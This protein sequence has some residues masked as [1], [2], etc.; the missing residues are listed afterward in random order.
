MGGPFYGALSAAVGRLFP[1][2]TQAELEASTSYNSFRSSCDI[3]KLNGGVPPKSAEFGLFS[4]L[5]LRYGIDEATKI[6]MAA[7]ADVG[8]FQF[9]DVAIEYLLTKPKMLVDIDDTTIASLRH[10]AVLGEHKIDC[11]EIYLELLLRKTMD[12]S[13]HTDRSLDASVKFEKC[14]EATVGHTYPR[15]SRVQP[16]IL[17]VQHSDSCVT[18]KMRGRP[19]KKVMKPKTE[20]KCDEDLVVFRERSHAYALGRSPDPQGWPVPDAIFFCRRTAS[21]VIPNLTAYPVIMLHRIVCMTLGLT[22][23]MYL[24]NGTPAALLLR[25]WHDQFSFRRRFKASSTTASATS[26]LSD[27]AMLQVSPP[28]DFLAAPSDNDGWL[29]SRGETVCSPP[30]VRCVDGGVIQILFDVG[31]EKFDPDDVCPFPDVG[32]VFSWLGYDDIATT[33]ECETSL[34]SSGNTFLL[35]FKEKEVI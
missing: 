28:I 24:R 2:K 5:R 3:Q 10:P 25:E 21:D 18:T 26:A 32:L 22:E 34:S 19:S 8:L 27:D 20:T 35:K 30:S 7:V 29:V 31:W 6:A 11:G 4:A 16:S 14:D 9:S 1:A 15:I 33:Y 23:G 17:T 13:A 12:G